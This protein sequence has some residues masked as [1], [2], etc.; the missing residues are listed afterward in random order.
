MLG[1]HRNSNWKELL[2]FCESFLRK[3]YVMDIFRIWHFLNA[4]KEIL[5]PKKYFWS[6]INLYISC[7]GSKVPFW[8][9]WKIDKNGTFDPG[10]KSK[11][12]FGLEACFETLL[13]CHILKISITYP[14]IRKTRDLGQSL[15]DMHNCKKQGFQSSLTLILI[16]EMWNTHLTTK[17]SKQ[18]LPK[19]CKKL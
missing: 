14:K 3:S 15:F 16:S 11:N 8:Q 9:N 4:S 17:R 2:K 6:K 13:K 10:M 5:F 1:T 7:T 18:I 12:N 19:G